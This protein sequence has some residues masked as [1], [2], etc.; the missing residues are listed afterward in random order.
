[1]PPLIQFDRV[2]YLPPGSSET[3]PPALNDITLTI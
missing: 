3:T 1:M 2:T